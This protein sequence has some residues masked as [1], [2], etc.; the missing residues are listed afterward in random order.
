MRGFEKF[1][2]GV[3]AFHLVVAELSGNPVLHLFVEMLGSLVRQRASDVITDLA[4]AYPT[5][6]SA[7]HKDHELIAEA[8]AAGDAALARHRMHRHL[9]SPPIT[10]SPEKAP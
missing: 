2:L 1:S 10:P 9:T 3:Q 6:G 4:C 8:I 5:A 7:V